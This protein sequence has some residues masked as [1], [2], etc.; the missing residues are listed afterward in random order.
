LNPEFA[1]YMPFNPTHPKVQ[2]TLGA[3]LDVL[4]PEIENYKS[5]H[6]ICISNEPGFRANVTSEY[7]L[8]QYREMLEDKYGSVAELNAAYNTAYSSFDE[9]NMPKNTYRGAA[10][11]RQIAYFNDYRLFNE[12]IMTEYH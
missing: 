10:E 6:S 2:E 5:L 12:A 11:R 1:D 9:V 8:T 3:F 7:Y 4:I